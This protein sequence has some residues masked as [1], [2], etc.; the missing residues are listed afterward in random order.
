MASLADQHEYVKEKGMPYSICVYSGNKS[1]HYG[2]VLD[3]D[4]PNY[5]IWHNVALWIT[6]IMDKADSQN[7]SPTRGLRFPDNKR[8]DGLGKRQSL[9]EMKERI[10]VEDLFAWLNKHP[11][12][13]PVKKKPSYDSL[14]YDFSGA[15]T[16]SLS[17]LPIWACETLSRLSKGEQEYRN[18]TWFNLACMLANKG[19]IKETAVAFLSDYFVEESDFDRKEWIAAI[20]SGYKHVQSKAR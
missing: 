10:S 7:V 20:E 1:L 13:K 12:K 4:L 5:N 3:S 18:K 6:N 15:S 17:S 19:I 14:D 16:I 11:D 8:P 2:I 9:I